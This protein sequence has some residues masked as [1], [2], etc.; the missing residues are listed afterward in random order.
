MKMSKQMLAICIF[1]EYIQVFKGSDNK[2]FEQ[3]LI[4][5]E[6]HYYHDNQSNNL[7]ELLN[8]CDSRLN[9]DNHLVD[10][11]FSIIYTQENIHF[12]QPL[13]TFLLNYFHNKH[14][15]LFVW[16]D[17]YDYAINHTDGE[18]EVNSEWII[19]SILPLTNLSYVYKQYQDLLNAFNLQQ[20][21]Q[22]L[23]LAQDKEQAEQDFA[24][25]YAKLQQDKLALQTELKTLNEKIAQRQQPNLEHLLSF[26]PNI[27][28]NFWQ[29]VPPTELA[30]LAGLLD[31][32]N[33]PSPYLNPSNSAVQ[34]KK[35]QFQALDIAE[36]QRMIGFCR[37][38]RKSYH[39]TVHLEFQPL[40]GELD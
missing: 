27:F 7:K 26:L 9:L 40:I 34:V 10:V 12:I 29:T 4:K 25:Q 24:Q 15:S 5:G 8:E 3:V 18:A 32:P 6:T 35:R 13:L 28:K 20:Q 11:N 36:Q 38:L 37:E 30:N 31:V 22:A 1:D 2:T 16:Q 14:L 23:Q 17:L 33:V 39:L 19:Q 21:N